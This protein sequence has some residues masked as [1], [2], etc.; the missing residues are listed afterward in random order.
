MKLSKASQ[1]ANWAL[2]PLS[3]QMIEYA[4]NDTKYLLPLAEILEAGTLATKSLGM[5]FRIV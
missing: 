4:I 5:V 2:R 1:K 3:N